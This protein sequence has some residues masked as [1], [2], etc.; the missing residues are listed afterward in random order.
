MCSGVCQSKQGFRSGENAWVGA[1]ADEQE[2][3][4]TSSGRRFRV[5]SGE[6]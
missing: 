1:D 4:L 2:V 5:K 6:C 3:G